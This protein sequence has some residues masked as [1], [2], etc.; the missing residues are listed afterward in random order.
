MPAA[1]TDFVT[2]TPLSAP[3]IATSRFHALGLAND[4]PIASSVY[5]DRGADG[6]RSDDR[7]SSV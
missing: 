7:T 6:S 5:H 3:R 1:R 4:V 2:L